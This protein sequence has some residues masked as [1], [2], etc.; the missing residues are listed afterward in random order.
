MQSANG[1]K[2]RVGAKKSRRYSSNIYNKG[3]CSQTDFG[4][5]FAITL[6]FDL[7]KYSVYPY[8]LKEDLNVRLLRR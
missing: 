6:D 5:R 2:A 3:K 7:F 1:L 4:K 8:G